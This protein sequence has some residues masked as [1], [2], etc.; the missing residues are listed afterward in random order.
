LLSGVPVPLPVVP[1]PELDCLLWP[2]V[3]VAEGDVWLPWL[4]VLLFFFLDFLSVC[5]CAEVLSDERVSV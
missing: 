3:P 1:E 4:A 2:F 5:C